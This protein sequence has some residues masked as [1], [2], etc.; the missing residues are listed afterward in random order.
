MSIADKVQKFFGEEPGFWYC[1]LGECHYMHDSKTIIELDKSD[2]IS[3]CR[4]NDD[5]KAVLPMCPHHGLPLNYSPEH[6]ES[7]FEDGEVVV[8]H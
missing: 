6:S 8:L 7:L 4:P 1:K 5:K 2:I 3:W